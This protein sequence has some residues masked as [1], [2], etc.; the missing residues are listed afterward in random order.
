MPLARQGVDK[1][2]SDVEAR[3]VI[4]VEARQMAGHQKKAMVTDRRRTE[5]PGD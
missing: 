3:S 4:K 5:V 2:L 1:L